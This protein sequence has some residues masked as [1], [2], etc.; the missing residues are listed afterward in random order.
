MNLNQ[1]KNYSSHYPFTGGESPGD[2]VKNVKNANSDSIVRVCVRAKLFLTVCGSWTIA[3]L[4]PLPMEFSRKEHWS[5]LPFP[6]P[7]NLPDPEREPG[8][9]ASPALASG[10]FITSTTWETQVRLSGVQDSAFL[11]NSQVMPMLLV[12]LPDFRSRSLGIEE[13]KNADAVNK[14]QIGTPW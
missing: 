12:Y 5:E 4:A 9:L 1:I 6:T 7:G 13:M 14:F 3:C 8:S 10:L 2:L 11:T